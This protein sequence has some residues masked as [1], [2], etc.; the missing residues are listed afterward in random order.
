MNLTNRH[1]T[2][3]SATYHWSNMSRDIRYEPGNRAWN[4]LINR[5]VGSMIANTMKR[6]RGTN[7]AICSW[8]SAATSSGGLLYAPASSVQACMPENNQDKHICMR[9][10]QTELFVSVCLVRTAAE[11]SKYKHLRVTMYGRQQQCVNLSSHQVSDR[12][13]VCRRV[14]WCGGCI[15]IDFIW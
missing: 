2:H 3:T 12:I 10:R 6:M 4:T 14:L 9:L 11:R 13:G 8:N 7:F 15:H 1:D 5:G